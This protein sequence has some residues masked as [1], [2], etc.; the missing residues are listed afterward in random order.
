MVGKPLLSDLTA[1]DPSGNAK[2]GST[3]GGAADATASGQAALPSSSAKGRGINFGSLN[4]DFVKQ[5]VVKPIGDSTKDP[6]V[7][8]N[9]VMTDDQEAGRIRQSRGQSGEPRGGLLECAKATGHYAATT[10]DRCHGYLV[11]SR[12][13][14]V[15]RCVRLPAGACGESHTRRQAQILA[16]LGQCDRAVGFLG[17]AATGEIVRRIL[18][19]R[20]VRSH[21]KVLGLPPVHESERLSA[22]CRDVPQED[23]SSMQLRR[24]AV[25]PSKSPLRGVFSRLDKHTLA[26]KAE[27]YGRRSVATSGLSL[28]FARARDMMRILTREFPS[29]LFPTPPRPSRWRAIR[30]TMAASMLRLDFPDKRAALLGA[31]LNG[32]AI[33]VVIGAVIG[34]PQV[35]AL[36]MPPWLTGLVIG[37]LLSAADAVITKVYAPILILGAVGGAVIGWLVGR[38][39]G[40]S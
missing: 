5:Q 38:F 34:A 6:K 40:A 24:V 12:A 9:S 4:D 16:Q 30:R 21:R 17:E 2:A 22:I 10:T 14:L 1:D 11:S 27:H 13:V 18:G 15:G 25:V 23:V 28:E 3:D 19:G 31:F 26:E 7:C 20:A 37:I 36:R 39:G 32:L 33:G 29:L 35:D 8:R